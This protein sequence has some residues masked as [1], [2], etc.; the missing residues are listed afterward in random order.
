MRPFVTKF[1]EVGEKETRVVHVLKSDGKMVPPPDDY[2]FVELYCED[3]NCD[4][5]RVI[6][7]VLGQN[8]SKIMATISMGFDPEDDQAGPFL[9]PLNEQSQYAQYFLETFLKNIN[10]DPEYLKRLERH[11]VMF[12]EKVTGKPYMGRPF[13]DG[14][15]QIRSPKEPILP[16]SVRKVKKFRT[17]LAPSEPVQH[18]GPKVSRNAP[19]PCGSGKKYK[20]CCMGKDEADPIPASSKKES[21]AED[22][23]VHNIS[24]EEEEKDLFT[25]EELRRAE[26]LV[27]GIAQ[28]IKA[29][30]SDKVGRDLK[31]LIENQPQIAFA[32]LHLLVTSYGAKRP[33]KDPEPEYEAVMGLLEEALTQIRY[34]V[35]RKRPWA[36][37]AAERIQKAM[38]EKAFCVEMDVRVQRDLLQALYTSKLELHPSILT[39]SEELASYYGRFTT[40]KG[41]PDFKQLFD[42]LADGGPDNPFHLYEL[43]MADLQTMELE[44]QAY[45][46]WGM[47]Q[48]GNPLILEVACLMLLHPQKDLRILIPR[49]FEQSGKI[50]SLTP[51][52]LRRMI[53][54]RNWLPREER[55]SVDGLIKEA[56]LARIE[57]APMPGVQ[58]IET[59]A[60]FFDGAGM[61]MVWGFRQKTRGYDMAGVLVKQGQGIRDTWRDPN[62]TK[63]QKM[64]FLRD[65]GSESGTFQV[66]PDYLDRLV[67]HFLWVGQESGNPPPPGLLQA[68]ETLNSEYWQPRA[69]DFYQEIKAIMDEMPPATLQPGAIEKALKESRTWPDLPFGK[70]WF[71]DDARVDELVR[72]NMKQTLNRSRKVAKT[73]DWILREILEEKRQVW[74]ER[75]FWMTLFGHLAKGRSRLPWQSFLFVAQSLL[76]DKPL[77]EIPLMEAVA[78]RSVWSGLRRMEE[79]PT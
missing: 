31:G 35:D 44:A 9:D 39:K 58:S 11:Y 59:Y 45:A 26:T 34:S 25:K 64:S 37:E 72:K 63:A 36:M 75:L 10:N 27:E 52:I 43:I 5:R 70:S 71:E 23:S 49:V 55:P 17:I 14:P 79:L 21:P 66:E 16:A 51:V 2:A 76:S 29:G 22:S 57:C 65:I 28:R 53:G 56:R 78:E 30:E 60:S 50:G 47:L 68:A 77:K 12:K 61:Q 73:R 40:R 6:I 20:K 3:K 8:S 19:C 74:G 24:P 41:P 1:R 32:L 13:G 46:V 7:T 48:S 54:L 38:A 15:R 62:C 33:Q 42:K 67:S 69:L 4:C 18:A